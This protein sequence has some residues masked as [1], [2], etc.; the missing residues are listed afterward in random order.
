MLT[1]SDVADV[2]GVDARRAIVRRGECPDTTISTPV[3][4]QP[5]LLAPSISRTVDA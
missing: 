3:A 4:P 2:R 5:P 1:S